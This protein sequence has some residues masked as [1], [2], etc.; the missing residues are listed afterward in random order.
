MGSPIQVGLDARVAQLL[1]ALGR[2]CDAE[3]LAASDLHSINSTEDEVEVI[4]VRPDGSR[5]HN[6][7]DAFGGAF[8]RWC[9]VPL[10]APQKLRPSSDETDP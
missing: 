10:V 4:I 5:R 7:Q 6:F 9:G 2:F 8:I 1:D 3:G